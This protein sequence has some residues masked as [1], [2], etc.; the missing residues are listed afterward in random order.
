MLL[1]NSILALVACSAC[2]EDLVPSETDGGDPTIVTG[3]AL[4][5]RVEA[6]YASCSGADSVALTLTSQA[7]PSFARVWAVGTGDMWSTTD[8]QREPHAEEHKLDHL[9]KADGVELMARSL[10]AG[11]GTSQWEP[12]LVTGFPCTGGAAVSRHGYPDAGAEEPRI[13]YVVRLLAGENDLDDCVVVG[14]SP[15]ELVHSILNA[16]WKPVD[17]PENEPFYRPD[18]VPD[19]AF[20]WIRDCRVGL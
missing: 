20:D 4:T 5:P 6:F 11:V 9:G 12:N 1:W 14:H 7:R 18:F 16:S 15:D 2:S 3:A 17:D 19:G 10:R 13:T 8:L